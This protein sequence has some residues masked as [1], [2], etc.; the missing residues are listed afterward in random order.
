MMTSRARIRPGASKA[1][2]CALIGELKAFDC[3]VMVDLRR[4]TLT[5]TLS[6]RELA[7]VKTGGLKKLFG[8]YPDVVCWQ[9]KFTAEAPPDRRSAQRHRALPPPP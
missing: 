6:E 4:R 1:R 8:R 5:L 3:L 9:P 7:W 2:L